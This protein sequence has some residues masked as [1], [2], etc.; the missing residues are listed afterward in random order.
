MYCSVDYVNRYY[1]AHR[2]VVDTGQSRLSMRLI[3][4]KYTS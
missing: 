3:R 4:F 2:S 1:T